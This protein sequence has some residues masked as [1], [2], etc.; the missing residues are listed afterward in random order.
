MLSFDSARAGGSQPSRGECPEKLR[1]LGL[2][3]QM[4]TV[5]AVED[6]VSIQERLPK[7]D[8]VLGVVSDKHAWGH[9]D[10]Y[11][12]ANIVRSFCSEQRRVSRGI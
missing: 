6:D 5:F 7:L 3:G 1:A 8:L 10:T 12:T 2:A 9:N 4:P 11:D